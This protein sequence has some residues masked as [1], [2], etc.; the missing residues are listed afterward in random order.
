MNDKEL[1]ERIKEIK[2]TN[3]T[4]PIC[5]VY[6]VKIT[7][8]SYL[9]KV[10]FNKKRKGNNEER[11]IKLKKSYLSK[12]NKLNGKSLTGKL[13]LLFKID[14]YSAKKSTKNSSNEKERNK[15]L[16]SVL[17]KIGVVTKHN[18]IDVTKFK[19]L[20]FQVKGNNASK[21]KNN[22]NYVLRYDYLF[23]CESSS[24]M[25]SYYIKKLFSSGEYDEEDYQEFKKADRKNFKKLKGAVTESREQ[26][27]N[28]V[29]DDFD[30][31]REE[32]YDASNTE[33]EC[34]NFVD[35]FL[36]VSSRSKPGFK[37]LS[38]EKLSNLFCSLIKHID[39]QDRR[40]DKQDRIIEELKNKIDE[41]DRKIEKLKSINRRFSRRIDEQDKII[42]E[43][44]KKIYQEY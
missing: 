23:N 16:F 28:K 3:S 34:N 9:L 42:R 21:I 44:K 39:K 20:V 2:N 37:K 11:I 17:K 25:S 43:L 18:K 1:E 4:I 13:Y 30:R 19:G 35:K 31:V 5:V 7:D 22:P 29:I 15:K 36:T 27:V 40:I 24:S 10:V 33:T 6:D 14:K 8:D 32:G 26:K 12:G 38:I 41:Q